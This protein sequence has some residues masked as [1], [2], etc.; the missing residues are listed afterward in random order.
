ML[1]IKIFSSHVLINLNS[2]SGS[3]CCSHSIDF[4][5]QNDIVENKKADKNDF[6]S[7]LMRLQR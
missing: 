2:P 7:L 6:T 4:L 3:P 1:I 5:K